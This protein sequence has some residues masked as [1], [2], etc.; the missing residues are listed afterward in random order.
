MSYTALYRK[1]R[2]TQ[3]SDVKGQEA[4]VTTLK[5]QIISGRIGHAYLFCGTRGTGKT[6]VAKIFARAVNCEAPV[7]G[8]P[9]GQCPACRAMESAASM[10]VVEIDAAS[11]NGVD[12]IREIRDE[13]QYSP[14]EG[15]YRVYIIDEAHMLSTGA[16]N[17]LLKTLEEPPSYVIFILATTEPNRI[18][19]TVL[20][21]CQR[22][23]F[24]RMTQDVLV[25]RLRELVSYEQVDIED[26]ALSYIA[27]KADG[28]MRD[29][30]S[31][32]DQCIAFHIGKPL[33]Y[34]MVL[35]V[36]G[37]VDNDV[38][39]RFLRALASEDTT[40]ALLQVEEIVMS[41]RELGQFVQDFIWYMRN[42]L[43]LMTSQAGSDMLDLTEADWIRLQE[44]SRMLSPD[45]LIRLIRVFS[46][47]YNQ[48][49]SG[50][51]KRV[52]LEVAVIQATR[53][54]ME[55]GQEAVL[56]RLDAL[57][58]KV[59]Q[60]LAAGAAFGPGA[61]GIGAPP[62][63]ETA[64]IGAQP[65]TG[66]VGPTEAG[67]Q[68]GTE[69]SRPAASGEGAAEPVVLPK[70]QWEDLNLIQS[71][72]PQICKGI[73]H[74]ASLALP[75]TRVE[76]KGEGAMWVVFSDHMNMNMARTLGALERVQELV[77]Q[78]YHKTLEFEARLAAQG[79]TEVSYVS[80]ADLSVFHTEIEIEDREE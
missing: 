64:G 42:L 50:V 10:N 67:A 12:N 14:A 45:G 18:P 37:A 4:I 79:E 39:S 38:F 41:G 5:N 51:G 13:V 52:R 35:N 68:R 1:W 19:V 56:A 24:K 54:V 46:E 75:G 47:L 21:R 31:L 34:E 71:Q 25:G 78:N 7:D 26:K 29:A 80:D 8:S 55:T 27:K 49:R 11:N 6:T 69:E 43:L 36:L 61:A 59:A 57:E 28:G 62:G 48:M 70:A 65:G 23:D 2:P 66:T 60:G 15:K 3:F 76:P 40:G 77:E 33:T 9:C 63:T 30:I 32:L 53:P 17:A 16:F 44:E 72:W 20:S 73:E 58:R 74:A 22:Y